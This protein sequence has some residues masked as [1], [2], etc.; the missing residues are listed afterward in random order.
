[1]EACLEALGQFEHEKAPMRTQLEQ[2]ARDFART[3]AQQYTPKTVHKHAAIIALFIDFV[4]WDTDVRR[5]EE[6][7]GLWPVVE[8]RRAEAP[9]LTQD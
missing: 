5:I 2:C 3:L 9:P 8:A 1:M 6:E 4:C 7:T